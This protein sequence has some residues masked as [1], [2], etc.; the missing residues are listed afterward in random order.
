MDFARSA[1]KENIPDLFT[2]NPARCAAVTTGAQRAQ[3]LGMSA[4]AR[5]RGSAGAPGL[6][7]RLRTEAR[8]MMQNGGTKPNVEFGQLVSDQW[9]RSDFLPARARK[10]SQKPNAPR[11][12][13]LIAGAA[14]HRDFGREVKPLDPGV[15]FRAVVATHFVFPFHRAPRR[16]QSRE[17]GILERFARFQ[18]GRLTD[19]T[20]S[21]H[22]LAPAGAVDDQPVP[23]DQLRRLIARVRDDDVVAKQI[24]AIGGGGFV[25]QV[26]RA[27]A[28][29]HPVGHR[30]GHLRRGHGRI[31]GGGSPVSQ[32][33]G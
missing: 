16:F 4:R 29:A 1:R 14:A 26:K 8:A 13:S 7:H 22:F 19:H 17:T 5:E 2:E 32:L 23:A 11:R 3:V 12:A 20:G 31:V 24:I 33:L 30:I 28:D 10:Q 21:A 9:V 25:L 27:G 15:E 18:P 6:A